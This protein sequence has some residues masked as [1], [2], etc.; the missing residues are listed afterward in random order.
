MSE[1]NFNLSDSEIREL[2]ENKKLPPPPRFVPAIIGESVKDAGGIGSDALEILYGKERTDKIKGALSNALKF[3]DDNLD[4]TAVGK[5]TTQV[6]EDTFYPKDLS[7]MEEVG[8]Q[9]GS[10]FV[11]YTGALKFMK[12]IKLHQY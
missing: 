11:P 7:P 9:I 12:G 2:I 8:K 10:Y 1:E 5:A 4:K 6:L 3:I